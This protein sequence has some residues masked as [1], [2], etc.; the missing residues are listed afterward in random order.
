MHADYMSCY[1]P[2][3]HHR[4]AL[5]YAVSSMQQ[6]G[7]MCTDDFVQSAWFETHPPG[8]AK[9]ESLS[10]MASLRFYMSFTCVCLACWCRSSSIHAESVHQAH[11]QKE[12]LNSM[13]VQPPVWSAMLPHTH[14]HTDYPPLSLPSSAEFVTPHV[15]GNP[16]SIKLL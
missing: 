2:Q 4:Y 10:Q 6:E 16:P 3:K 8:H 5:S 7:K 12:A 13:I 11:K 14:T 15:N 9:Q 1:I